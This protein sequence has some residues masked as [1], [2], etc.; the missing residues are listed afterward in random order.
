MGLKSMDALV[1]KRTWTI[2]PGPAAAVRVGAISINL[3]PG[4]VVKKRFSMEYHQIELFRL[5]LVETKNH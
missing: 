5:F 2:G 4:D 1:G 3:G